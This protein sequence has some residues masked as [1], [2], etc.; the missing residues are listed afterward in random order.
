MATD[1]HT[2]PEGSAPAPMSGDAR[3]TEPRGDDAWLE[4]MLHDDAAGRRYIDDGGFTAGVLAELPRAQSRA[5][6]R[7]IVP[8]AGALG[9]AV[10]LVGLSGGTEL[11]LSLARLASL[12]SMS[13]Q[14]LLLVAL[15][16]GMLYWI[17]VG[18]AL[19]QR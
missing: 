9:F 19:Q 11:S 8:A 14:K 18:A 6:Y 16:L 13:I 15:P 1:D 10:G 4:A 5:R 7:W 3:S 2:E 12:E 17:G